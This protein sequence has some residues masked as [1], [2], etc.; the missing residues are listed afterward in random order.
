MKTL[1]P[2][3]KC[4]GKMD[5]R[6][7]AWKTSRPKFNEE[8]LNFDKVADMDLSLNSMLVYTLEMR[9]SVIM[10]DLIF[11][12]R[13]MEG[14]ALSTRSMPINE[15][16]IRLS[17]E[18][19][20]KEKDYARITEMF[21]L[22]DDGAS[23][24]KVRDILPCTVSSTYTFTIDF[25][26]LMSLCKTLKERSPM[27]FSIYGIA[28]LE[29]T[30]TQAEFNTTSVRSS[31]EYYEIQEN[32]LL[33]GIRKAGNVMFGH[34]KMK[35]ALASQFLRQHYSKIKIGLWND[36]DNYYDMNL[37]QASNVDVCFYID[38]NSYHRLM[39][40]RAHWV[41]DH[42][43]D[44]WGGIVG[45]YT[46]GMSTKQFWEFIPAGGGKEDPY[47]ADVYNRVLLEDPGI[48][49]P[50]MTEW[51]GAI[52]ERRKEVGDS[53]ILDLYESL[54]DEGFVKD[55]PDNAHRK[56]YFKL[57]ELSK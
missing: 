26:V 5:F 46:E 35:M 33:N 9:S 4:L 11:S 37:N 8:N 23:R 28:M 52:D 48:P 24:D 55:N 45:D 20:Y 36:I 53:K 15:D 1:D 27:L 56:L 6:K 29:A 10:R 38:H 39:S 30:G 43:E 54:F 31:Y 57:L 21:R 22:L 3:V 51:R 47:W 34:Y 49:C 25:R 19:R 40:M 16:T 18:F 42:S 17:S 50:I 12:L 41:I 44:M 13:P 14:W 2:Y 7:E 32:E